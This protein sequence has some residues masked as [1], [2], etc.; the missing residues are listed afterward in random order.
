MNKH[1]RLLIAVVLAGL[2][3]FC[4]YLALQSKFGSAPVFTSENVIQ[5]QSDSSSFVEIKSQGIL[6]EIR[7]HPFT[8]INIW[9][10]WCEPCKE[11][12]PILL[13]LRE[14]YLNEGLNVL[15]VS[16]DF[17]SQKNE[18]LE[19]LN[20][21]GVGFRTYHKDEEDTQFINT[22]YPQWSGAIPA[23]LIF[24]QAGQL[25]EH[26]Q[27]GATAEQFEAAIQT[28]LHPKPD[29]KKETNDD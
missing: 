7:K 14:K 22:L 1:S 21:Q 23:T 27:G 3:A 16:A 9:A 28:A 18:A 4:G 8:L 5:P 24:N 13:E 19:F 26:W 15:L 2:I 20:A 12:F 10:T 29:A 17:A 6:E 11:E 25:L